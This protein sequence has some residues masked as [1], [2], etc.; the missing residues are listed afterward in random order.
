V[1]ML[2]MRGSSPCEPRVDLTRRAAIHRRSARAG[3]IYTCTSSREKRPHRS[4]RCIRRRPC[5]WVASTRAHV[6]HAR[7]LTLRASGGS[8]TPSSYTQT[9]R[10]LVLDASTRVPA[11]AR[12]GLIDLHV[13]FVVDHA[14]G[15]HQRAHVGHA[16]KLT[17]RAS[18]GSNTPSSY[19]QTQRSCWTHLHVYQQPR[20]A[21]SSI[22][23]LHSRRRPCRWV[24]STR[25]HVGHARKL[26]LRAS[27][28]SNTPSSYTQTQRSC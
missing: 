20:E 3:R 11:A 10:S 12:S 18:G 19:T 23:T 14:D 25:A 1:L 27:G 28:G 9:Q 8:N 24:A 5:R 7:K 26:T 6:G 16:R 15:S 17:L 13:A 21:A 22:C 4:A 2:V